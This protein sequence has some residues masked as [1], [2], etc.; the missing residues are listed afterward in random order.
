MPRIQTFESIKKDAKNAPVHI[1]ISLCGL[2]VFLFRL[3]LV[4]GLGIYLGLLGIFVWY[5]RAHDK[6]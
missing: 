5:K 3:E 6:H 4:G 1:V 2:T